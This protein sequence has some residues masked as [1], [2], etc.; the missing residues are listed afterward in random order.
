MD[1]LV[2]EDNEVVADSLAFLLDC[3]GHRA[4]VVEDGESALSLLCCRAFELVLLDENLPGIK[5]SAVA[6]SIANRPFADRPFMV[7]MT[8]DSEDGG[9][10]RLFDVCLQKPFSLEALLQVIEDAQSCGDAS[11]LLA[12]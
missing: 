6:L 9:L 7:S 11:A 5:G 10:T 1:V 12:A 2:V 3:Y 4:T 8:G